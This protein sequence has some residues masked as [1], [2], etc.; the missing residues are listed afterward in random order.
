MIRMTVFQK[1]RRTNIFKMRGLCFLIPL[2]K[3]CMWREL[4]N[5][6]LYLEIKGKGVECSFNVIRK[7]CFSASL[8]FYLSL[9]TST[10]YFLLVHGPRVSEI[11]S[12]VQMF[13]SD[14]DVN[15]L[16]SIKNKPPEFEGHWLLLFLTQKL[17]PRLF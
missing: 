16:P 17:Y 6:I 14:R 13:F 11:T 10:H 8:K 9:C 2:L 4:S 15:N 7:Q 12:N 1:F 5:F 3:F